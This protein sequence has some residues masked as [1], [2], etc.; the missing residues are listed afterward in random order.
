VRAGGLDEARSVGFRP[1]AAV[2]IARTGVAGTELAAGVLGVVGAVLV[3]ED[4]GGGAAR[5]GGA[6]WCMVRAW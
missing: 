3:D 6:P 4:A 5:A 2:T 1:A